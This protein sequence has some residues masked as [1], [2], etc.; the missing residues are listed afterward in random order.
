MSGSFPAYR[1]QPGQRIQYATK[2]GELRTLAASKHGETWRIQPETAADVAILQGRGLEEIA[3]SGPNKA[4]L[5]ARAE[6]LGIEGITSK[7]PKDQLTDLIA[8]A[9]ADV[10][11]EN[12]DEDAEQ[13][14][15]DDAAAADG[16]AGGD[17]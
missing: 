5:L 6:E 10:S 8:A 4:Q 14:A 9:E 13:N 7:T 1:A 2:A 11:T 16:Q 17:Q 12:D 3:S 15:G